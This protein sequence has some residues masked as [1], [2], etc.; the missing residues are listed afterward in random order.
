M[1]DKTWFLI[2]SDLLINMAA[3]WLGAVLIV[4]NFSKEKGKR[5]LI[6]LTMDIFLATVSLIVAYKLRTF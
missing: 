2:I 3:G 4:P 6:I 5:K 1:L